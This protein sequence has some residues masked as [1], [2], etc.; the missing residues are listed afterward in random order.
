MTYVTIECHGGAFP[1]NAASS[2]MSH[3]SLPEE[4]RPL[5]AFYL[6]YQPLQPLRDALPRV[7]ARWLHPAQPQY[8][9]CLAHSQHLPFLQAC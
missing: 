5:A 1:L 4:N 3:R 9:I 7:G 2:G 6:L 8:R